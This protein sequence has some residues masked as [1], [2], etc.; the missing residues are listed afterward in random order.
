MTTSAWPAHPLKLPDTLAGRIAPEPAARLVAVGNP[1]LLERPLIGLLASRECPGHVLLETL[2]RLPAWIEADR[3]ILSGFHSPLE[4][5]V[6]RSVL[7]RR[8]RVVKVLARGLTD[9]RPAADEYAPL[10]DG[11]MLILSACPPQ[12]RCTTRATALERNRLVL[13][14]AGEIVAPHVRDGSP[15]AALLNAPQIEQRRES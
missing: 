6:L 12:T 7:R 13:A 15:L 8:G 9:Y 2:D 5:Q 1:A 4:Q 14:L 3:V 11:R 10:A